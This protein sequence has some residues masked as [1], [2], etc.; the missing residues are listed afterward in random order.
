V[1]LAAERPGR[2]GMPPE[3]ESTVL[4]VCESETVPGGRGDAGG[5]NAFDGVCVCVWLGV[6]DREGDWAT[7]GVGVAVDPGAGEGEGLTTTP[8]TGP[9][10]TASDVIVYKSVWET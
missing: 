1:K 2:L 10:A 8:P 4:T 3:S 7:A 9:T 6:G 5:R